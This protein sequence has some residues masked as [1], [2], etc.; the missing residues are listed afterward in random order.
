MPA[1]HRFAL[2]VPLLLAIL[3]TG[4]SKQTTPVTPAGAGAANPQGQV[5][6]VMSDNPTLIDD[7]ASEPTDPT[8]AS[9]TPAEISA[10]AGTS[11]A[12]RPL[13]FWRTIRDVERRFE[14][15]FSDTDSTGQPTRAVV[16]IHKYFTGSFNILVADSVGEG[17]PPAAH[18]IHKPLADHWV[19][20]ILLRRVF[21]A[22]E[23]ERPVWRIVATSGVRITSKDATS[24]I[25]SVRVQS[26]GLDTTITDPLAFIRLRA[27]LKLDPASPVTLTVTT[28]RADDVVLLYTRDRRTRFHANG[29]DTYTAMFQAPDLL[30]VHHFG[31]DALSH[32]TLFDDTAPYDSQAWIEPYIVHPIVIASG[33]P[34]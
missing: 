23:G 29:D 10:T 19:R 7:D 16:T 4:C 21:L 8:S 3:L 28:G 5:A 14:F 20:R 32:G 2:T 25:V 13:T 22:D 34:D 30:G 26:A 9:A 18:V 17:S 24:H 31:V 1:S 6:S 27:I 33:T 12:I 15:A 11:A